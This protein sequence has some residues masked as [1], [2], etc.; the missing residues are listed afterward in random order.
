MIIGQDWQAIQFTFL[1]AAEKTLSA[2]HD[3]SSTF[4]T[5]TQRSEESKNL[6]E[7]EK[8]LNNEAY[9][10]GKQLQHCIYKK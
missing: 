7:K 9:E 1:R 10:K 6:T 8:K 2:H 3:T 4:R 5:T